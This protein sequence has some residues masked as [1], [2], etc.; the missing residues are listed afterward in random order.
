MISQAKINIGL[1]I[2]YKRADG[3]HEICSIFAKIN[4][5]DEIHFEKTAG[6]GFELVSQNLLSPERRDFFEA[7]S[8]RGNPEKNI[9]FR[10]WKE[11]SPD[12]G[13]K[14]NLIK[15]I[16]PGGGLG[17]G[18]SNA[19]ELIRFVTNG[20]I[21]PQIIQK[22]SLIGAD[23][24]FFLQNGNGLVSGIGEKFRPLVIAS[25]HGLLCIPDFIAP[26][27]DIY[28]RLKKPL[29]NSDLQE[30]CDKAVEVLTA[31]KKGDWQNAGEL[32]NEF[33]KVVFPDHPVL[34]QVKQEFNAD[35]AS[36]T[37]SGSCIYGLYPSKEDAESARTR[38][39]KSFPGFT[40]ICFEY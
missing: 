9:L 36:M 28:S 13:L 19:A 32:K 17:G 34:R 23:I 1:D 35:Y 4:W 20:Q 39:E 40:F 25:G 16:P 6:K 11:F 15:R 5:G 3:Y 26:T 30:S 18:S 29:Q 31:L 24:P 27:R 12:L 14:V 2:L 38:L 10:A 22:S 37:G 33:E 21:T 7:V 8:E